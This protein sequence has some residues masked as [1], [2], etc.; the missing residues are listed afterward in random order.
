LRPILHRG[1]ADEQ[2]RGFLALRAEER[3]FSFADGTAHD[4]APR[5][6]VLRPPAHGGELE[7]RTPLDGKRRFSFA[8]G[9]ALFLL[10][11]VPATFGE[12]PVAQLS[13]PILELECPHIC[14]VTIAE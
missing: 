5:P 7:V 1:S 11:R 14:A 3:P 4:C 9:T 8:G 2:R 12:G 10:G 6:T 13:A